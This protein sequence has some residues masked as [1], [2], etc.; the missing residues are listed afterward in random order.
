MHVYNIVCNTKINAIPGT[1]STDAIIQVNR[2]IDMDMPTNEPTKLAAT[3]ARIPSSAQKR[4]FI[5]YLRGDIKSHPN[6]YNIIIAV[7]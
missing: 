1:P 4:V 6:K 3:K 5:K 2:L 7:R